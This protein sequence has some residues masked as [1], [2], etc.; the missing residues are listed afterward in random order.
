[1][2]TVPRERAHPLTQPSTET[3]RLDELLARS[4]HTTPD[5]PALSD[6]ERSLTYR[7][8]NTAVDALAARLRSCEVRPGHRVGVLVPKGHSAIRAL[9]G[10]L[11][12][13]AV[14]APL[15]CSDPA[16]RVTRAAQNAG[17]DFLITAPGATDR[18]GTH[19][20]DDT[21]APAVDLSGG[22]RLHPLSPRERPADEAAYILFTSGSTGWPK[23]VLLTHGNVLHFVRWAVDTLGIG[24]ADRIGSQASLTFDLSTFDF[25]GAALAG[26]SVMILPE[27]LKAFPR[28]VTEWLRDERISVFYAVPTLYRALIERGGISA[29]ALPD[30]RVFAFAGEPFPPKTLQQY[31]EKFP[32]S[33]WWNLYGPTETN[34]CTFAAVPSTWTAEDGVSIGTAIDGVQ[35]DLAGTE[36]GPTGEGEIVV[37]GPTVF[38][39]YL[40]NGELHD[41]TEPWTFPDGVTRRAYRSGDLARRDEH[42]RLWLRGRRDH[43]VKIRGHRI[44]L[45]DVESAA[46]AIPSVLACA[47]V[48]CPDGPNGDRLLLYAVTDAID[49][50]RLRASLATALPRR[51]LPDEVRIVAELPLN[52]RGKVDRPALAARS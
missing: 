51:M 8:L 33:T 32:D 23:G 11:R 10:V 13:Q 49:S 18:A 7:E 3:T 4:A 37:A 29:D 2:S 19:L 44:D 45:G 21:H 43:Q 34:V 9:Y 30:L 39:G 28:N 40:T 16:E 36:E 24:P 6:A 27:E 48:L 31:I 17:L 15:D 26:A 5:A 12:A 20:I 47:A 50:R 22:L 25:F 52:S 1:M 38:R 35:V 41:P 14:A 46:V 42:G